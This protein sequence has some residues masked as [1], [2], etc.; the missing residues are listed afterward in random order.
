MTTTTLTTVGT[1]TDGAR[2]GRASSAS[3][4]PA[5]IS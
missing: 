2:V 4:S 5:P 1:A 3:P